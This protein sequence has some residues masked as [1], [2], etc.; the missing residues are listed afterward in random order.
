MRDRHAVQ[1]AG[2]II[3]VVGDLAHNVCF[4]DHELNAK[5]GCT[6]VYHYLESFASGTIIFP[7][8]LSASL[9]LPGSSLYS[10][11]RPALMQLFLSLYTLNST[12]RTSAHLHNAPWH[13]DNGA[14]C[15]AAVDT[16]T[17]FAKD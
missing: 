10:G 4:K 8:M 6:M 12:I 11:R 15:D 13:C 3:A 9:T 17:P 16:L 7:V 2:G 1:D 14:N 5:A